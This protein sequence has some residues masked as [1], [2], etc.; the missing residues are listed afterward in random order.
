MNAVI[1]WDIA[2]CSPSNK[3]ACSRCALRDRSLG[4]GGIFTRKYVKLSY[5]KTVIFRHGA[6]ILLEMPALNLP[7]QHKSVTL[8]IHCTRKL[9]S[10]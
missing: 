7:P 2:R 6:I 5:S 1:L 3:A 9:H 8:V 4:G 10:P